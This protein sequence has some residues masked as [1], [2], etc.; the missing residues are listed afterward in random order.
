VLRT[1]SSVH[2]LCSCLV[3]LLSSSCDAS[4]GGDGLQDKRGSIPNGVLGHGRLLPT[5]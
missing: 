3:V 1:Y 5:L 2:G 4:W